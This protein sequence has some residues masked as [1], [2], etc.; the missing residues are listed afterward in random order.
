MDRRT[1]QTE[2]FLFF[3]F[4]NDRVLFDDSLFCNRG[5]VNGQRPRLRAEINIDNARRDFGLLW[6]KGDNLIRPLQNSLR[7][8][9]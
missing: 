9:C 5:K 6:C 4:L 1:E 3:V 8:F 2:V 7:G